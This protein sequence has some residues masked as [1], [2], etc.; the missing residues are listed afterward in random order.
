MIPNNQEHFEALEAEANMNLKA[1]YEELI[2]A[3]KELMIRADQLN[4]DMAAAG[5]GHVYFIDAKVKDKDENGDDQYIDYRFNYLFREPGRTP[6]QEDSQEMSN[7]F[8]MDVAGMITNWYNQG[9][10]IECSFISEADGDAYRIETEFYEELDMLLR[11][12]ED[13]EF[14]DEDEPEDE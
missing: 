7:D 12:D 13:E 8:M 4:K 3:H 11:D 2:P 5:M 10:A 9:G 14:N 1:S 6:Y